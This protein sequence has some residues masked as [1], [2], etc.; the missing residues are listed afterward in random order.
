MYPRA[1]LR[2]LEGGKV[3][4]CSNQVTSSLSSKMISKLNINEIAVLDIHKLFF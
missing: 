1:G 4:D 2:T 3:S